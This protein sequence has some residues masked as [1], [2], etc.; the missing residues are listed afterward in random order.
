MTNI[1]AKINQLIS[2]TNRTWG[3]Y[4]EDID[5]NK[6]FTLNENRVFETASTIKVF[7]ILAL[8]HKLSK[9]K[10]S[11]GTLLQ[12]KNEHVGVIGRSSGILQYFE[13]KHPL[14][15]YN[16]ALL[17][18][19]VSDNPATNVLIEYLGKNYINKYIAKNLGLKKTKLL[20]E[21]VNFPRNF[22]LDDTKMGTT[23]PYEI[24]S[25]LKKL[26]E[27]RLFDEKM[28][29]KIIEILSNQF[30]T[31]QIPRYLPTWI[32]VGIR[33]YKIKRIANKTGA[34]TYEDDDYFTTR[35]DVALIYTRNKRRFVFAIYHEGPKDN[36]HIYTADNKFKIIASRISK[37]LFDYFYVK[38]R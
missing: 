18:I 20:T 30:M 32:N 25:T 26:E 7:I 3:I 24:A 29:R 8:F 2:K 13:H 22:R 9:E 11:S 19:I 23:T 34:I 14:S 12:V 21:R 36:N 16:L 33:R 4:A 5:T 1:Q 38:R 35:S 27:N 17:M 6:K 31:D 15:L 10:I 28:S 37:A